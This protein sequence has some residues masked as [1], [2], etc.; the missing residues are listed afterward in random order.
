[1]N[2]GG[3]TPSPTPVFVRETTAVVR[4]IYNGQQ[5]GLIVCPVALYSDNSIHPI[6]VGSMF[7]QETLIYQ[8]IAPRDAINMEY[9]GLSFTPSPFNGDLENIE[10]DQLGITQPSLR[11]QTIPGYTWSDNPHEQ[12]L[13]DFT[14]SWQVGDESPFTYMILSDSIFGE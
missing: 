2:G 13:A 1:M 10:I 14:E 3:D 4:N 6:K 8:D 7:Y 5:D 9:E 11:G 12:S